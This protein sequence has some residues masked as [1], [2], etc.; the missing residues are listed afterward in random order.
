MDVELK[1]IYEKNSIEVNSKAYGYIRPKHS[2][3]LDLMVRF[4]FRLPFIFLCFKELSYSDYSSVFHMAN[5][6]SKSS[7]SDL[8]VQGNP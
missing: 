4:I 5:D 6:F 2:K 3:V 1:L 7:L 8:Q